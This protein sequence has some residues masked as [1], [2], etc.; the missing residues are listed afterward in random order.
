MDIMAPQIYASVRSY[1][2]L[3]WC[4]RSEIFS[5]C[6]LGNGV[7]WDIGDADC[8]FELFRW[9]EMCC[10]DGK[11]LEWEGASVVDTCVD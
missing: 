3:D 2:Q 11:V 6:D 10:L 7:V 8:G 4:G 5:C 1:S 9:V